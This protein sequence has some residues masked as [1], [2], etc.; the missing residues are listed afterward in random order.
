MDRREALRRLAA[1]AG[2][3][4]ALPSLGGGMTQ[5]PSAHSSPS[6]TPALGSALPPDPA[7]TAKN[8]RPSFFD[9]HQ[10][11][12]VIVLSDLIIPDTDT[13][14]AKAAFANRFIDL[15]LSASSAEDQKRYLQALGWLD[16][17]CLEKH[18]RPFVQFDRAQQNEV[19]TLLT[20]PNDDPRLAHGVELFSILK[21][22]IA[23]AY[24][25]SEIGT[26]QE[27]KYETNPFQPEFPGC[28]N[29]EE[30]KSS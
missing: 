8:W 20:H 22:S 13:P 3:S 29:P 10:N 28:P 7:L 5:H 16:G 9:D 23:R 1:G 2:A 11:K 12:T 18:S 14:G 4:A 30:H 27:L 21:S 15:L 17:H 6:A 26:L 19:L 25:S 24:Y